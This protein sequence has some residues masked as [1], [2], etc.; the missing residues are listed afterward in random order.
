MET[1]TDV[2][3]VRIYATNCF[4]SIHS[5]WK[6]F[7]SPAKTV[8]HLRLWNRVNILRYVSERLSD[9][10]DADLMISLISPLKPAVY[11]KYI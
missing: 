4:D 6:L 9:V 7:N 8:M 2:T 3:S 11:Q 5:G 10:T 1:Q